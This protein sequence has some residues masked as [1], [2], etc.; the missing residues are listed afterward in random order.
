MFIKY[1]LQPFL[2]SVKNFAG[3]NAFC[4]NEKFYSYSDFAK[5]ISRIRKVIQTYGYNSINIGL[6]V[7]DDIETYASIFAIW[8]EGFAYVPLHP[9]QPHER[10]EEIILQAD[11][12]LVLDSSVKSK[13][14]IHP[15]INSTLLTS[16]EINL[17][18]KLIPDEALAYILFT[19]GS[20]GKP[21]GVQITRKNVSAFLRSF[22][23][24]G[25]QIDQNDRCLQAFDLTFDVSVQSFLV[26]LTCGAC[27]Y[28]IPHNQ[29]KYSYIYGLLEDHKIT[30]G[31]MAPSMIRLLK[32]YFAEINIPGMRYNI[33]TAEA[34][35]LDLIDEWS[36]CIPDSEIYDF[37]G[38]TEATIY[39]TCYKYIRVGNNKHLNGMVSIGKPM[40]GI[41]AIVIDEKGKKLGK[42]IKGE[43]CISGDQVT[44]GYWKNDD[45]NT[46]SF[47]EILEEGVKNRY[48]KTGDYCYFDNDGDILLA[49]RLDHQ[50]KIQ[51]YRV[52]LSEIEF[53]AS[54]YLQ[55]KAIVA[56]P[57]ENISGNKEIALF[58]ESRSS[59][60]EG[61][62]EYLKSKLP[63]YMIPS[64]IKFV[65]D[66]PLNSSSKI[67]RIK[68]KTLL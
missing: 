16:Y 56:I 22:W 18:P 34:S 42:N 54:E 8:L 10:N 29:I 1:I 2:E 44:P 26:P 52:E 23:E 3:K 55:G 4:I 12:G 39:C 65:N 41:K 61:L 58:I 33:L 62:N 21:K 28:T 6:V 19:S 53:V 17:N 7:N 45:K 47:F 31:A 24:A 15:V 30:F 50:V 64:K 14:I 49:G 20:T 43:L 36:K 57:V 37:Y 59:D 60:V 11:I 68:M 48:Y 32:P 35:P 13:F 9:Q 67:D 5:H 27:V 38:P 51:G 66:F 63:H 40:S 25:F 46:E